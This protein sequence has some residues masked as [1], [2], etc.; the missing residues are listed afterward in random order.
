MKAPSA[1]SMSDMPAA[2]MSGSETTATNGRPCEAAP[3]EIARIAT[4]EAVSKPRP[5][6][7]PIGYICQLS[8]M[9]RNRCL[10][11]RVSTP[12]VTRW[13]SRVTRLYSPRFMRRNTPMMS[14]RMMRLSRPIS[15][16]NTPETLVPTM[17]PMFF[18]V[19]LSPTTP[20]TITRMANPSAS[21]MRSTT[22]E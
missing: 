1:V 9:T 21:A 15:S 5:K 19:P 18:S 20:S 14:S 10:N 6:R 4:S 12:P 7:K 2:K 11:T 8:V 17:P 16:R 3:A 13:S 22:D